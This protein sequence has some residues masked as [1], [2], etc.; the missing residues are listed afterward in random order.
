[1]KT[2][3][4]KLALFSAFLLLGQY[5]YTQPSK[6]AKKIPIH[7][8]KL[9][10]RDDNTRVGAMYWQT[11][12]KDSVQKFII[13]DIDILDP[14]QVVLTSFSMGNEVNL[15]FYDN[16]GESPVA[17]ISSNGKKI[18]QK[19]FRTVK[20]QELG[21][22]S[23]AEG[24]HY[25]ILVTVGKK[26]PVSKKP[27]I[28]L[29][30]D[31]KVSKSKINQQNTEETSLIPSSGDGPSSMNSANE[32]K[33]KKDSNTLL[34]AIIGL[35]VLIAA[36][37]ILLLLKNKGNK[38]VISIIIF[39]LVVNP[40]LGQS[41]SPTQ[42]LMED[43][44][45]ILEG[46]D[47]TSP[48]TTEPVPIVEY[49][50]EPWY[51]QDPIPIETGGVPVSQG[52]WDN[53]IF[54]NL[55]R[56]REE[57]VGFNNLIKEYM[58]G[59]TDKQGRNTLRIDSN[60]EEMERMSRR[61][62]TL[63][64][65]V[66]ILTQQDRNQLPPPDP[67]WHITIY[68]QDITDCA[69]CFQTQYNELAALQGKFTILN[70]HYSQ[71][72]ITLKNKIEWGNS[73]ANSVPGLSLGWTPVLKKLQEQRLGWARVYSQKSLEF[74]DRLEVILQ[75]FQRCKEE[76][77]ELQQREEEETLELNPD[78]PAEIIVV[79]PPADLD[80]IRALFRSYVLTNEQIAA[81]H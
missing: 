29:T 36:V 30:N 32:I 19:I 10:K 40:L 15:D 41:D 16:L 18:G 4:I 81:L 66:E 2:I 67:G 31:P 51:P 27:L 49:D 74:M 12:L 44:D 69:E 5:A 26:F 3:I 57:Y 56:M 20:S 54:M 17:R 53:M 11:S 28:R 58:A 6:N 64:R 79:F 65:Q 52:E 13:N 73:W 34:Y 22:T 7:E 80:Q 68:C 35:L 55:I 76:L 39:M 43:I 78:D 14:V 61:L 60:E 24:I 25:I 1:M 70:S 72:E 23:K 77:Q 42:M 59:I 37:L 46:L 33:V 45:K 9:E 50:G 71:A 48:T 21:I 75:G 63:E 8:I 62:Q 47:R 38:K